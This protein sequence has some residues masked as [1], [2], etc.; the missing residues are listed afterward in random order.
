LKE[1]DAAEKDLDFV[2]GRD[3]ER[4][5]RYAALVQRG[6]LAIR[7]QRWPEAVDSLKEAS[8]LRPS[9]FEAHVNLARAHEGAGDL[10][11]AIRAMDQ[12][13]AQQPGLGLLYH[14]RALLHLKRGDAAAARRDLEQ[15]IARDKDGP[16]PRLAAD[17]VALGRLLAQDGAFA[18]ALAAHDTAL[19]LVRDFPLAHRHRAEALLGLAPYVEGLVALKY[20]AEAGA[21]LDRYLEVGGEPSAEVHQARALI[22]VKRR[23]YPQAIESFTRALSMKRT[24]AVL[25]QR[26]WAYA[27]QD[28]ARLALADFEEALRLDHDSA[29]A[30]CGRGDA[31]VKLGRIAEGVADV[32]QAL[33]R[34]PRSE[35]LK[36]QLLYNAACVFAQAAGKLESGNRVDRA[37]LYEMER[38]RGQATRLLRDVLDCQPPARRAVFWHEQVLR[39][40][41]LAPLRRYHDFVRLALQF[42]PVR[43][44]PAK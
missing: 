12:A 27:L 34:G 31:R 39:A 28:A 19:R 1:Y 29:D 3:P 14:T 18:D 36:E 35:R 13:V 43:R 4:L 17:H 38:C 24:A 6:V 16:P 26:G 30:L 20:Y 40:P 33:R 44:L 11:A 9:G 22:H 2:R 37:T 25:E 21:A 32:E 15:A 41:A 23:E 42:E 7:R 5:A 10:G 8:E